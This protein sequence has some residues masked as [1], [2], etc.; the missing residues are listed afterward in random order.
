MPGVLPCYSARQAHRGAPQV[1]SHSVDWSVRHLKG[2]PWLGSHSVDWS[3]RH[4]KGPPGWGPALYSVRR[5]FD[6][7]A[8]LLLAADAG[9]GGE[10]GYGDGLHHLRVT[11]QYFLAS[12]A[13]WRSSTGISHH[14]L[15]LHVPSICS[16]QQPSLWDCSTVPKLQ[17]PAAVPSRAPVFL[18]GV[19]VPAARTV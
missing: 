4:L 5:A 19:C 6:G 11:Q 8:S 13:A 16:Q 3:V 7:P 2:P 1:G 18:S 14:D 15:L 12:M 17:L 10:S 9:R